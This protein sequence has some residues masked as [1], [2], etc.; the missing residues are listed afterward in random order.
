MITSPPRTRN[1]APRFA[2]LVLVSLMATMALGC[3]VNQ[4]DL[5]RWETT[6]EGPKR[7][8]AV[9]LHDKYA[10]NL[11]V[12]AALSLIRMKLRKGQRVGIE[13]LVKATLVCDPA[14]L[15]KKKNEPCQRTKLKPATRAKLVKSL[16]ERV[17]VELKKKLPASVQG[18]KAPPDP[19][20]KYKDAALMMLTY[21]GGGGQIITDKTLQEKLSRAL[22]AWAMADFERRLTDRSQMFGMEQLLRAIG[23]ESVTGLP[24]LITKK[25][26]NLGRL[27]TLI[28]KLASNKTKEAASVRLVEVAKY[29]ESAAWRKNNTAKLQRANE[30]SKQEVKGKQFAKQLARYQNESLTRVF[31]SMKKVGGAAV[32]NYCLSVASDE[33]QKVKQRI[34]ALAVIEGHIGSKNDKALKTLFALA[35]NDKTPKRV[36]DVAFRRIK[37]MPRKKVASGLLEFLSK[38]DWQVRRLAGATLLAMSKAKHAKEFLTEL[39]NRA[40]KKNFNLTEARTYGAYL[41]DLKGKGLLESIQ[42]FMDRAPSS[43]RLTALAYWMS[44]GTKA[45]LKKIQSY[46]GEGQRVPNCAEEAECTY[47]CIVGSGKARKTKEIATVGDFVSHCVLPAVKNNMAKKAAATK[48]KK[49]KSGKKSSASK[50]KKSQKGDKAS[51]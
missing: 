35:K 42:P 29:T 12:E 37:E 34:T 16:L 23:P 45:Q 14:F 19:S 51:K 32:V 25:A 8:S 27:S 9:V 7:L 43:A 41:A 33:K 28:K 22:T 24:A 47:E 31:A 17:I 21:S 26:R 5:R 13:R 48:R 3:A 1:A 2:T 11:R 20:F 4:D 6:L 36:V 18:K 10:D 44:K 15:E 49:A 38:D 46:T 30:A 50:E 39:G 40:Q